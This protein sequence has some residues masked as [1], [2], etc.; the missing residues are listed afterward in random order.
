MSLPEGFK[1]KGFKRKSSVIA[2]NPPEVANIVEIGS[3]KDGDIAINIDGGLVKL[4]KD[5]DEYSIKLLYSM[6]KLLFDAIQ[7]YLKVQ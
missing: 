3:T 5:G 7:Q 4:C 1:R 2:D 6:P